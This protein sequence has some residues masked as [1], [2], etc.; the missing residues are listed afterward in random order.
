MLPGRFQLGRGGGG[1]EWS[2]IMCL[3]W[4]TQR[5]FPCNRVHQDRLS[6]R[7]TIHCRCSHCFQPFVYCPTLRIIFLHVSETIT[8]DLSTWNEPLEQSTKPSIHF[9]QNW[10]GLR[11][12]QQEEEE[13]HRA[14]AVEEESNSL[15]TC[16][17]K[18]V[19]HE[20]IFSR[21]H[22]RAVQCRCS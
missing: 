5:L 20:V 19:I 16:Q 22:R 1:K 18:C 14:E 2:Q 13:I 6:V 12:N 21:L 15:C 7:Q 3:V 4:A 11:G 9:L 10:S 17:L 8:Y